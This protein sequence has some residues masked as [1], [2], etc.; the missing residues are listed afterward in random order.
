LGVTLVPLLWIPLSAFGGYLPEIDKKK[1]TAHRWFKK[2]HFFFYIV[3]ALSLFAIPWYYSLGFLVVF[4]GFEL[5]VLNSVHRRETHSLLFHVCLIGIFYFISTLVHPLHLYAEIFVFNLLLGFAVGSLSHILADKF[6]IKYVHLLFPLEMILA[7][8]DRPRAVI[9]NFGKIVTGSD[10]ET[11]FKVRWFMI[12][13]AVTAGLGVPSLLAFTGIE[14]MLLSEVIVIFSYIIILLILWSFIPKAVRIVLI[15][16]A[17]VVF[18]LALVSYVFPNLEYL[19]LI[20]SIF[21]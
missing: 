3:I 4:A 16:L 13:G 1:T 8:K 18:L 15:S 20:R 14:I 19:N 10:G 17:S 11:F 12:C 9:P 6:N 7:S 5:M 2:Y 21:A